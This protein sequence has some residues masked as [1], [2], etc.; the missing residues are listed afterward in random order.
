MDFKKLLPHGIAIAILLA[1]AAVFYAPNAFSGKV[2]PQ[3]DN[4]KAR[5][6]Q[7]EMRQYI[8]KEGKAPLWTNSAFGGMPTY[9]IMSPMKGNLTRPVFRTFF[10]FNDYTSVW[11]QTFAAML[12]MYL[13]LM[14]L[15]LDWRVGVFGAL[16]YGIT[17]YNVDILE[18]GHSTKMAALAFAPGMLAGAVLAGR[19]K[20]FWGGAIL[21]LFT[22]MQ[23][24][25]NHIQI[26]YYTFLII[27][28]YYLAL[29]VESV[30][31]RSWA[32]WLKASLACGLAVGLGVAANYSILSTSLE[33]SQETIRGRSEL[34]ARNVKRGGNDGLD[35]DYAFGW[36]YGKME[37]MTLVAA[38]AYGGG[39]N[40]QMTDT[41]TYQTISKNVPPA[42]RRNLARQLAGLY[43]NGDQPFVG[44][45]IYFGAVLCLLFFM[46]TFLVEGVLKWWL[47]AA[48]FFSIS[49]AWGRNFDLNFFW[50]HNLPMFNK[51]RSVSMALGPA[52]MCSAVLAALGLQA[53]FNADISTEKKQRSLVY[54]AGIMTLLCIIAGFFTAGAG[55][56]DEELAKQNAELIPL[57]M[58]DR[59]AMARADAFRSFAFVAVA[60][61]LLWLS[62]RGTL[63]AALAVLLISGLAL[64]DQWMVCTRTISAD[65]FE[66]KR[67]AMAAPPEGP[68]D[69][70]IKQ[71][72]DPHYR[73]LDLSR[74]DITTNW[75]PSY[76]HKSLSGYHAAKLQ[77]YQEVIDTF[78]NGR[79]L[80]ESIDLVGMLN[81]K[82]IINTKG[83]VMQNPTALGNAWFVKHFDIVPNADA[84]FNALHSLNPR[85]SAVIQE[86]HAAQLQGFQLQYDSTASIKL[87]Q[88]HPDKLS[89]EY[90]A[91]TDQLA[92]FSEIY[93]PAEKGWKC[94]LDGQ[95]AAD[96]FKANYLIRAAKLPAGQN[97]KFE[98]RFEPKTYYQGENIA[99]IASILTLLLFAAG[100]FLR[101]RQGETEPALALADAVPPVS[102]KP[103]KA[104]VEKTKKK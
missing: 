3:P 72:K 60:V 22:A 44:T 86:K 46:A 19:G 53:F 28:I 48:T 32:N 69:K 24:L 21:A 17:S 98:M 41:K 92:L 37:T 20:W 82:Y 43:Y 52:L 31:K 59:A 68:A 75:T 85:D 102:E 57:L 55:P 34:S 42:E 91:Q 15:K 58:E 64:A 23:V 7:T 49:I 96:M 54:A 4:D 30:L 35:T 12:C 47:V 95:P 74:G 77:R 8:D 2:L 103:A 76:F 104:I 9:Q 5:A 65:N 84:E 78:F 67:S 83:E 14:A 27:G 29:L 33:Y 79:S 16:A 90:S 94:Y 18:A 101:F 25:A 10:L 62:M 73:V 70:Q 26:T 51:F 36:S 81:G 13:L 63:K 39:A 93:Y 61:A 88:Y 45:A 38:H 40:E 71:D 50:F 87:T 80:S 97:R 100:L 89:Y 66:A 6:M 99:R 1:I 11:A 56:N